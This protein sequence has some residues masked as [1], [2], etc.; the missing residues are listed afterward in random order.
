MKKNKGFTLIELLVVISII[1]LLASI[2]MASLSQA[3]GKAAD[4]R[5][6]QDLKQIQNQGALYYSVNNNSYVGFTADAKASQIFTDART[7]GDNTHNTFEVC[8]DSNGVISPYWQAWTGL[9]TTSA[10]TPVGGYDVL[11][12]DGT[13]RLSRVSVPSN[14]SIPTCIQ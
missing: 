9:R 1:G 12:T 5:V 3:R 8:T 7:Y 6:I 14:G 4:S 10:S 2:V 11:I 13:G